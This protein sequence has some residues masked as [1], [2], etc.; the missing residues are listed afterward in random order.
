MDSPQLVEL[1]VAC[2]LF[3]H[4]RANLLPMFQ[5]ASMSSCDV[6]EWDMHV[7]DAISAKCQRDLG[8]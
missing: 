5:G 1:V 3:D 7:D 6:E 8:K 4:D 2:F